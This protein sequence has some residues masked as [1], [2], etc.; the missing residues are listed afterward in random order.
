MCSNHLRVCSQFSLQQNP[1]EVNT[2]AMV[3]HSLCTLL[4]GLQRLQLL[5]SS[6]CVILT[7]TCSCDIS[8]TAYPHDKPG[9]CYTI[10]L[11]IHLDS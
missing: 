1:P 5:T 3:T 2:V 8:K 9:S 4:A 11:V 6:W 10:D 7:H